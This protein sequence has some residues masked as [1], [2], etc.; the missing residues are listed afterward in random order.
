MVFDRAS[1]DADGPGEGRPELHLHHGRTDG[2]AHAPQKE[3]PETRS[4][5]ECYDALRAADSGSDRGDETK[6]EDA[7]SADGRSAS[8][9]SDHHETADSR[10]GHSGWDG[11]DAENRPALE[12]AQVSAERR[13]HI[14][15]GDDTGGGH[16]HGTGKPGKTEFPAA[17]H[18]DKIIATALD[19]ARK[20]DAPPTRQDR[21]DSWLCAGTRENVEVSVVIMR[22]GE[23]WTSWP[24]E[25]GPGV[26]RNPK[27]D[28]S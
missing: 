14:L 17:W 15:D 23:V 1:E 18:D 4:R 21:N 13:T 6:R 2:G 27:K 22:N 3:P 7:R 9:D 10:P 26:V 11:Y 5:A 12:A 24:E 20:P 19:V 28:K 8:S 16:R 25:G